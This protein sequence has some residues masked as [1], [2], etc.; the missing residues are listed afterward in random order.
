VD[1]RLFGVKS[2]EEANKALPK[3]IGRHNRKYSVAPSEEETAYMPLERGVKLDYVFA[4]R[5]TRK[6]VGGGE[7]ISYNN[8]T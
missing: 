7:S 6:I 4:T 2:V 5:T 8:V 1:L 3:L